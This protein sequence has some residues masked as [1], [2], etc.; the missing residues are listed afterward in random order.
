M[1][2]ITLIGFLFCLI[3]LPV[4][5]IGLTRKIKAQF[6]NRIGAPVFQPFFNLIKLFSK[7][8]TISIEASWIFRWGTVVNLAAV[9]VLAFLVPWLPF[10]P[11]LPASDLFLVIYM[12]A[13]IRFFTVI[14]ALDTGSPFAAFGTSREVTLSLLTEPGIVLSLVALGLT[15]HSS[16]FNDIFAIP[17]ATGQLRELALWL[18]AGT[19]VF[20]ASLVELS[21]MP[22]DDPCTHLELTMVHEAMLIENS[23]ANLAL[24]E[25]TYGLRLVILFGLAAQCFLHGLLLIVSMPF[26]SVC[27][28]SI[29]LILVAAALTALIESFA[30]KLA[31][32]KNPDFIAYSLTMSLLACLAAL[33][34]DPIG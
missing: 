31:W 21:R 26:A 16:N 14:A 7:S 6:Q 8:E 10:Q 23:A 12:F 32:R 30:V 27:V 17:K 1:S 20:L 13:L 9:L 19:G 34:K 25:L 15:V 28:L 18:L 2:Y 4:L 3:F 5:T 24:V 29:L 33:M 22:I 11:L